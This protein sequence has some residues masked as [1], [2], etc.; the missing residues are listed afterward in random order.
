MWGFF[1]I[2]LFINF[3]S[4][5]GHSEITPEIKGCKCVSAPGSKPALGAQPFS[6]RVS[7]GTPEPAWTPEPALA[8][9]ESAEN[10]V[11][12]SSA[13]GLGLFHAV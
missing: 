10:T 13:C 2:L 7:L 3:L 4:F 6:A 11:R 5:S 9:R 12:A 1:L 8:G